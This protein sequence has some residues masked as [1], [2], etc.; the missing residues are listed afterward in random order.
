[1]VKYAIFYMEIRK[2]KIYT[3]H[4]KHTTSITT[5]EQQPYIEI[6]FIYEYKK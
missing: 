1:M 2:H 5:R 6:I 4:R 3:I